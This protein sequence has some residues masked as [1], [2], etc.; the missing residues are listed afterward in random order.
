M[1]F[2]LKTLVAVSAFAAAGVAS[3]ATATLAT[4][5]SIAAEGYVV[6]DLSGTGALTFSST[7]IGAL[8]AGKITVTGVAPAT[9]NVVTKTNAITK[10]T[11]IV[12]ASAAAPV[13]SLTG[14]FGNGSLTVTE[15]T[16]LGGAKQTAATANIATNGGSLEVTNLRVDLAGKKV[17]ADLNGGNG[18]GLKTN[19]YLWDIASVIETDSTFATPTGNPNPT[20]FAYPTL[21]PGASTTITSYNQLKGLSI[22]APAFELFATSL[23][24]TADGRN[25]LRT[26]TDFGVINSAI[27]VKVTSAVPEPSTYALMGM[28]LVGVGLMA[29]RRRAAQ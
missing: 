16:T 23:G 8:N 26:V 6:S 2:A 7:L 25:S 12:S 15:V 28:G 29:R 22:N 10:A 21:A 18:V 13:S 19:V 1:K 11:S 9:A 3:A 4:G 17:Y 20:T 27:S 24:L 14:E 5:G